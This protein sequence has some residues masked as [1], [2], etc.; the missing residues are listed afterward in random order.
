VVFKYPAIIGNYLEHIC[1]EILGSSFELNTQ[2]L[3]SKALW[4]KC[5]VFAGLELHNTVRAILLPVRTQFL[6]TEPH[7]SVLA[8]RTSIFL[9]LGE[10][11][12]HVKNYGSNISLNRADQ[13]RKTKGQRVSLFLSSQWIEVNFGSMLS[14]LNFSCLSFMGQLDLCSS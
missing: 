9:L 10:V 8:H 6:H 7:P 14:T 13:S 2:Y 11:S 1:K 12:F 4:V 5:Q 3:M